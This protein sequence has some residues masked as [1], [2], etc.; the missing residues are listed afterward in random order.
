MFKK[1]SDFTRTDPKCTSH[2][3]VY[4]YVKLINVILD[5][6]IIPETWS[7]GVIKPIYKNKGDK[8]DCNNFRPI[9]ILSHL[10]KLFTSVLNNRLNSF[11]NENDILNESQ[12]GF[13]AKYSTLDH[14]FALHTIIEMLR[15]KKRKL[16]CC[17]VDFLP[18]S[19]MCP[20]HSCGENYSLK[21]LSESS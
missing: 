11:I 17:Y 13:R 9:T 12:A 3:M 20:G 19:I 7:I 10:G 14:I 4:I 6:C 5:T 18:P 15:A 2:M 16:F 1:A 21:V 8:T